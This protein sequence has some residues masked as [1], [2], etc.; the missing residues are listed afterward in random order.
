MCVNKNAETDC[1]PLLGAFK[2]SEGIREKKKTMENDITLRDFCVIL[3]PKTDKV[4]IATNRLYH[5]GRDKPDHQSTRR[6]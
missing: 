4:Y 1:V 6:M 3:Q 5:P 2:T